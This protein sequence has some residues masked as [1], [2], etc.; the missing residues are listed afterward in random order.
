MIGKND[1][2]LVMRFLSGRLSD[3]EL[4]MFLIRLGSS[5]ELRDLTNKIIDEDSLYLEQMKTNPSVF[6]F[7]NEQDWVETII[8][9]STLA[10]N[11]ECSLTELQC[12]DLIESAYKKIR[13]E[14]IFPFSKVVTYLAAACLIFTVGIM[15]FYISNSNR[16]NTVSSKVVNIEKSSE[17]LVF[18]DLSDSSKTDAFMTDKGS[19]VVRFQGQSGFLAE[20]KTRLSM[21]EK[22]DTTII[23]ELTDGSALFEVEK[24]KYRKFSVLTPFAKITV[25]G[26]TFRVTSSNEYSIVSVIEGSVKVYHKLSGLEKVLSSGNAVIADKDSMK[27]I[28]IN[29][30]VDIPKRD[31]LTGFLEN[32]WD[33]EHYDRDVTDKES[34]YNKVI[35]SKVTDKMQKCELETDSLLDYYYKNEWIDSSEILMYQKYSVKNCPFKNEHLVFKHAEFLRDRGYFRLA[36]EWFSFYAENFPEGERKQDA[37]YQTGWCLI[38][39]RLENI[40]KRAYK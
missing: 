28:D 37:L 19:G 7:K 6:G 39:D 33:I 4:K 40:E 5:K 24:G 16:K 23:L 8:C 18:M 11:K 15:T 32:Y 25:T 17:N 1:D 30:H 38:Q 35:N 9:E 2:E 12:S 3:D 22:K 27:N 36:I 13:R 26:T 14:K 29:I 34:N 10:G 21:R 20:K 31:L